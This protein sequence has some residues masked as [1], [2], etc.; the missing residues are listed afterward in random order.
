MNNDAIRKTV[1][2]YM[3][4]VETFGVKCPNCGQPLYRP[5]SLD[6]LTGEKM[7]GACI[8]RDCQYAQPRTTATKSTP[9]LARK[10]R[11]SKEINFYQRLS[12]SAAFTSGQA[13]MMNFKHFNV[14]S[15]GQQIMFDFAKKTSSALAGGVA[16]HAIIKGNTGTGKTHIANAILQEVQELTD[17]RKYCLFID[18]KAYTEMKK[19]GYTKPDVQ[20]MATRIKAGIKRADVIVFDDIGAE[21]DT[22]DNVS[23]VNELINATE[24]KS[25]IVTTNLSAPEIRKRY[26]DR[27]LSRLLNN[28]NGYIFTVKNVEDHR[29]GGKQQKL[30]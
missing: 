15:N 27:S 2:K 14:T 29:T 18:I 21:R 3:A 4:A 19:L 11:V 25:L 10:A 1:S 5:R 23:I 13:L 6:K 22:A 30:I 20:E 26:S 8:N 17:Y 12:V 16:L 7:A 24:N 9:D 28:S